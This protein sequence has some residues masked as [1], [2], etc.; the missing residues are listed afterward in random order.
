MSPQPWQQVWWG[1]GACMLAAV[2]A[3]LLQLPT[4]MAGRRWGFSCFIFPTHTGLHWAL[5]ESSESFMA[6][7][8]Q[9]RVEEKLNTAKW[10]HNSF[11]QACWVHALTCARL[12]SVPRNCLLETW[13][14]FCVPSCYQSRT[15]TGVDRTT[16]LP[17]VMHLETWHTWAK[18][19]WILTNPDRQCLWAQNPQKKAMG[20][21]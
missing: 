1:V 17:A 15:K 14:N 12:P 2:F 11:Q 4:T 10:Y 6:E 5:S 16:G 21:F 8:S 7:P 19:G 3:L 9:K 18:S 20:I 13:F